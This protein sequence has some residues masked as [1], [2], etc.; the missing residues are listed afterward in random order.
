MNVFMH[1]RKDTAPWQNE[2]RVFAQIPQVGEFLM[3]ASDAA[4]YEVKLVVYTPHGGDIDAEVYAE[5]VDYLEIMRQTFP[6]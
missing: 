4:W 1:T 5:E 6:R 3:P 2:M